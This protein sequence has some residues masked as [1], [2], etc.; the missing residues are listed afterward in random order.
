MTPGISTI[1]KIGFATG[2]NMLKS[3]RLEAERA[4]RCGGEG[5]III[6]IIIINDDNLNDP[7]KVLFKMCSLKTKRKINSNFPSHSQKK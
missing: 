3:L 1:L 5:L 6:I 7:N 4:C 2:N